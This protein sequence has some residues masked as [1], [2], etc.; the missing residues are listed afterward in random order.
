MA[1]TPSAQLLLTAQLAK[2]I[3]ITMVN[4]GAGSNATRTVIA[5]GAAPHPMTAVAILSILTGFA[6]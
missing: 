2:G 4:V 1:M 5:M 6:R 3:V